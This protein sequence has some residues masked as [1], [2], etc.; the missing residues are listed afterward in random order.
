[1]ATWEKTAAKLVIFDS[2]MEIW[3]ENNESKAA[4]NLVESGTKF[5]MT[6]F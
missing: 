4:L 2:H 3:A 6:T 1:M 5:D